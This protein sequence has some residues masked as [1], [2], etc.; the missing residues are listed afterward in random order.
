MKGTRRR[1]AAG[2]GPGFLAGRIRS[3]R[4]E[5]GREPRELRPDYAVAVPKRSNE[6]QAAI[7]L[8]QKHLAGN[9][10]VTESHELPDNITETLREVDVTIR[11]EVAGHQTLIGL[12]CR[13]WKKPQTVEWIEQMH[14]KHMHLPTRALILVSSSGFT[15]EA[16]RKVKALGI[17]TRDAKLDHRRRRRLHSLQT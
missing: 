4:R 7:Y 10:V 16:E 5:G 2:P 1:P 14:G 17:E 6:F 3:W 8:L 15:K 13:D 9:S 12:E 11:I